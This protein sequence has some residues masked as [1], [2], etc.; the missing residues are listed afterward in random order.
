MKA[1]TFFINILL[2]ISWTI[3]AQTLES[4]WPVEAKDYKKIVLESIE[5]EVV[6][7]NDTEDPAFQSSASVAKENSSPMSKGQLRV[8][9]IL[10]K[11]RQALKLRQAQSNPTWLQEKVKKQKRWIKDNKEAK[12]KWI[13]RKL[14]IL[15]KWKKDKESFNNSIPT[16]KKHLIPAKQLEPI[17]DP[18]SNDDPSFGSSLKPSKIDRNKI[19]IIDQTF[20]IPVKHQG[21]RATCAA[22]SAI[23]SLEIDILRQEKKLVNLSE[24]FFFYLSRPD[25]HKT[26]CKRDGSW[27][28]LAFKQ[29]VKN[30]GK[31]S[32]PLESQ[33]PYVY[34]AAPKN[35]FHLPLKKECSNGS[36]QITS[37]SQIEKT[38]EISIL[39]KQ[40]NSIVMGF[41]VED[42]FIENN[43]LVYKRA[44]HEKASKAFAHTVL[45]VGVIPLP[46]INHENIGSYCL[47]SVNSWGTG[48]GIGGYA[49]LG[50]NWVKKH[51]IPNKPLY[52]I[53]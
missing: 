22:F 15:Q 26:Q 52:A 44:S 2:L 1:N 25:C 4:P 35:I 27:P 40:R 45:I 38:R 36:R 53:I 7:T 43:G 21:Q 51:R 49:C 18:D 19:T 23:R 13:K 9:E 28:R 8:Q 30:K 39:T 50:E 24:E 5:S 48:W 6:K 47:L 20:D 10:N 32:I 34:P 31:T 46:K 16:I 12:A 29:L 41:Y 17:E 11:K 3:K 37:F 42:H 33:C 14:E